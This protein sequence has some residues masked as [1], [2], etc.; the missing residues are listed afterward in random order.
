MQ[1]AVWE[2]GRNSSKNSSGRG[3]LGHRGLAHPGEHPALPLLP[4]PCGTFVLCL[5]GCASY[6]LC[7][8]WSPWAVC[9]Q[10]WAHKERGEGST[11][12]GSGHS[13]NSITGTNFLAAPFSSASRPLFLHESHEPPQ[14][15]SSASRGQ[16]LREQGGRQGRTLLSPAG[17]QDCFVGSKLLPV[18]ND[19]NIS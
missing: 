17:H 3:H 16:S 11:V 15:C 2:P 7:F 12:E 8:R 14:D 18:H 10:M 13:P 9:G 6:L 19:D 1:P 5:Q 4:C